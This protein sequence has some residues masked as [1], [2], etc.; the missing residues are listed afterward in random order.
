M[1]TTKAIPDPAPDFSVSDHGSLW[2][3]RSQN[4]AARTHLEENVSDE[5]QWFAGALA[6]ECRYIADLVAGLR[7]AGYAVEVGR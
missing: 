6:V 3:V 4:D 5:A 7:D 2:L 1:T